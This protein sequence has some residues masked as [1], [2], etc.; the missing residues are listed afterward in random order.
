MKKT[1][2]DMRLEQKFRIRPD[3]SYYFAHKLNSD[4]RENIIF[5]QT[6]YAPILRTPE[7]LRLLLAFSLFS[8]QEIP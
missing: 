2:C 8:V 7:I 4:W 1:F 5:I 6:K 3:I